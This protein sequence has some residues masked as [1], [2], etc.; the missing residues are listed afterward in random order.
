MTNGEKVKCLRAIAVTLGEHIK[1][2]HNEDYIKIS[3]NDIAE[4][5]NN[6]DRLVM[7]YRLKIN[8][9]N[10]L[11]GR[12]SSYNQKNIELLPYLGGKNTRKWL[13]DIDKLKLT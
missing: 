11:L 5:F 3:E 10:M 12:K 9:V 8:Y 1:E 4:S 13:K 7:L 2:I 6:V